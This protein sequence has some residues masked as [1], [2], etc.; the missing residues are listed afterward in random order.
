[1]SRTPDPARSYALIIGASEYDDS[2]YDNMPTITA[3]AQRFG[4]LLTSSDEMWGLP[5][6]NV[7]LLDGN[8]KAL[9][10]AKAIR[11]VAS[12]TNVD[13]LFVYLSTHGRIWEDEHVPDRNLHFAFSDSEYDWPFTHVPFLTVRR[14][15]AKVSNA[16][17][18]VL[19]IDS[20]FAQGAFLGGSPPVSAPSVPG[21]CTLVATKLRVPAHASGT[22][23][24]YGGYPAFSGALIKV[25]EQGISG[26]QE[27]LTPDAI[28]PELCSLLQVDHPEPDMRGRGSSVFLCQN[29]AY[30]SVKNQLQQAELLANLDGGTSVN[31][32]M[33]ATAVEDA[34]GA[35]AGRASA[36]R[37]IDAFGAKRTAQ[38]IHQLAGLLRSRGVPGLADNADRLVAR[39]YACRSSSEIV[40]LIHLLHRQDGD[41]VDVGQVLTVL[42]SE[43]EPRPAQVLTGVSTELSGMGCVHCGVIGHRLDS[44]MLPHWLS[45]L[46]ELLGAIGAHGRRER[47]DR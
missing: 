10:A 32:A 21:V 30:R 23:D 16:A 31:P 2:R 34:H 1:M 35:R 43:K 29:K 38:E 13:G 25:I 15:L 19:V 28:F 3:S 45:R 47:H 8:V 26:P 36:D 4:A 18:I 6:G 33:Y 7:T 42:S 24:G 37:L 5:P 11:E 46:E 14:L 44:E 20:C 12:L 41:G 17:D 9:D 27:W 22:D 39:V 40:D